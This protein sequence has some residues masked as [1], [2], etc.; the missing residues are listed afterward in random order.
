MLLD[1]SAEIGNDAKGGNFRQ[2]VRRQGRSLRLIIIRI[3][4]A[5]IVMVAVGVFP[6]VAIG[7]VIHQEVEVSR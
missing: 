2:R 6:V 3:K 5:V 4:D 1:N 7:E